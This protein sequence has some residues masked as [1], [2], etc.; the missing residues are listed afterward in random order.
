MDNPIEDELQ[1]AIMKATL[2]LHGTGVGTKA[3]RQQ[4]AKYQTLVAKEFRDDVCRQAREKLKLKN[5]KVTLA[6]LIRSQILYP[7]LL[8]QMNEAGQLQQ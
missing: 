4:V 8:E 7:G 6:F 1:R 3:E 5:P 2:Q